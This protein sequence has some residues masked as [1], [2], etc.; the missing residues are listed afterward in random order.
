M[1]EKEFSQR[2]D[3]ETLGYF[4]RPSEVLPEKNL[5]KGQLPL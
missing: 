5:S 1:C 3:Q 4:K 2:G